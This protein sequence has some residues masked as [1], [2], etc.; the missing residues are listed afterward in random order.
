MR[1]TKKVLTLRWRETP[2][3]QS[4]AR[5][6]PLLFRPCHLTLISGCR[7]P[8][9]LPGGGHRAGVPESLIL[10]IQ[11]KVKAWQRGNDVPVLLVQVLESGIFM[12]DVHALALAE[13]DPDWAVLEYQPC[14]AFRE[15]THLFVQHQLNNLLFRLT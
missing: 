5:S 13:D 10:H 12:K 1:L 2:V 8:G 15:D 7:A 3:P 6:V 11:H 9:H 4:A 14:L